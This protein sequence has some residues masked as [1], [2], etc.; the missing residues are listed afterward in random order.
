MKTKN[1]IICSLFAAIVSILAQIAIP[2]P[3]SVPLTM[4]TLGIGL[5]GILLG[6]KKG[7]ISILI[8]IMLG[9]IG[10]PIFANFTGGIGI[11][12][13][14]T[15]GF[16]LSFPI[17]AFIIGF[18]S[19]RTCKKALIFSGIIFSVLINYSI[20]VLQFSLV[21]NSSIYK[22]ILVCVAPF[23]VTDLLKSIL[24]L[25]VGISLKKHKSLKSLLPSI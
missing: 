19:E 15:G 7:F 9:S 11:I 18:I 23:V 21:T 10:A 17:M 24:I 3:G 13:G 12:L 4:Q 22:S 8:Y 20:G 1:L 25:S 6:A 2:L 16:I 5:C 14:P